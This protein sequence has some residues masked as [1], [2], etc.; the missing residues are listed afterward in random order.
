MKLTEECCIVPDNQ[1]NAIFTP[2]F[3][4]ICPKIFKFRYFFE[5]QN[6]QNFSPLYG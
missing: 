5:L 6:P 4:Q 2:K 3:D 1:K